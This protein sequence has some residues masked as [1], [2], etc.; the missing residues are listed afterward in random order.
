MEIS[1]K[2]KKKNNSEAV[3]IRPIAMIASQCTG[4]QACD[5][6]AC[7]E[8]PGG[9]LPPPGGIIP[10]PDTFLLPHPDV[11]AV[12]IST[13][14]ITTALN[15]S[16][17]IEPQNYFTVRARVP[18]NENISTVEVKSSNKVGE[19]VNLVSGLG[20]S[21]ASISLAETGTLPGRYKVF[22]STK[23]FVGTSAK[24]IEGIIDT[25][26]AGVETLHV[27]PFG[28][29]EISTQIGSGISASI[30]RY[31]LAVGRI[32][33]SI[34]F[35][36]PDG[37]KAAISANPIF[38][39]NLQW[40]PN[41]VI[42]LWQTPN[43]EAE[44]DFARIGDTI[45][46][47]WKYLANKDVFGQGNKTTTVKVLDDKKV[48]IPFPNAIDQTLRR[49]SIQITAKVTT[50]KGAVYLVEKTARLANKQGTGNSHA[51]Q[52]TPQ[53]IWD[54]AMGAGWN[55]NLFANAGN[56]TP[57]IRAQY[58][59]FDTF[60]INLNFLLGGVPLQSHMTFWAFPKE[61]H[62]ATIT[63]ASLPAPS[64]TYGIFLN[65]GF[66]STI[67]DEDARATIAHE[68]MHAK[69]A[70]TVDSQNL[71]NELMSAIFFKTAQRIGGGEV[72]L[73]S[74]TGLRRLLAH[75]NAIH[76]SA[77]EMRAYIE[78]VDW[79]FDGTVPSYEN[80]W[81]AL[82]N[83]INYNNA[84][85]KRMAESTR[86]GVFSDTG[87][88]TGFI[89]FNFADGKQYG[90]A[91]DTYESLEPNGTAWNAARSHQ[92][93]ILNRLR[94]AIDDYQIRLDGKTDEI[95]SSWVF[96]TLEVDF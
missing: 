32:K 93:A 39:R 79:Q 72:A 4:G 33:F 6:L 90:L 74:D 60:G 59:L 84:R 12:Q 67:G 82:A 28:L 35:V 19:T 45:E 14:A 26:P 57:V 76:N 31:K 89:V 80:S 83:L 56:L 53:S 92:Y 7:P 5:P 62:A 63:D 16:G 58:S 27:S 69:D 81:R 70:P 10:L 34:P 47:S 65:L 44:A 96:E 23:P 1:I 40:N 91:I 73:A 95:Q 2:Y 43:F 20:K 17:N 3:I 25:E 8:L 50:P 9:P 85:L 51:T 88:I 15:L 68:L 37:N 41:T 13:G 64:R 66:L 61:V 78:E 48:E 54:I 38:A 94:T 42:D 75:E 21:N 55:Q 87:E 22:E 49:F 36:T 29:V 77:E 18:V 24:K 86:I 11:Q 71:F 30:S 46:W 52:F